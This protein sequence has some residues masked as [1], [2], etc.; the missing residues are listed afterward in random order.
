[1]L[2]DKITNDYA[3]IV[4]F[5]ESDAEAQRANV[6]SAIFDPIKDQYPQFEGYISESDL[7]LGCAFPFSN[8]DIKKGYS[9]ADLGCAAGIDSFIMARMVGE[10]GTVL[11]FD[12]TPALIERAD[13]IKKFHQIKQV[14][15]Q[16]ADITEIPLDNNSV[17]VCTSNGVFSLIS[18]LESV[19]SE[20]KRILK[21][22]GIFFVYLISIKNQIL[23]IPNT[24]T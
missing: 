24:K 16:T 7:G 10:E 9:V 18:D 12:I 15:F 21:P 5:H 1:M 17:D 20:V 6:C 8:A 4:A 14:E 19:F 2:K 11:G 3:N 13:S 22:N 23:K